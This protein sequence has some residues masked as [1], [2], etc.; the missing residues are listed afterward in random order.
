MKKNIL[1]SSAKFTGKQLCQSLFLS[2]VVGWDIELLWATGFEYLRLTLNHFV[3][4]NCYKTFQKYPGKMGEVKYF[5][6]KT[7]LLADTVTTFFPAYFPEF[8]DDLSAHAG[9]CAKTFYFLKL[10]DFLIIKSSLPEVFC[11]KLFWKIL[12]NSP[13]NICARVSFLIKLQA[14]ACNFI[15]KET[16][17]QVFS[18]EFYEISRNSFFYRSA[19]VNTSVIIIEVVKQSIY[20]RS[21]KTYFCIR[22]LWHY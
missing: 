1:Q 4:N 21:R 8:W 7:S 17:A 9:R 10:A 22:G 5:V 12:Q 14:S 2:K 11:K 6:S 19:L 18:C 13:E 15:K 3:P 20:H 16:L